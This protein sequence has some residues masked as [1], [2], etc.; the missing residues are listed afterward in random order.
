MNTLFNYC[1]PLKLETDYCN[2]LENYI[3]DNLQWV[4]DQIETE[5]NSPYWHQVFDRHAW[6]QTK[7]QANGK[8][9][10]VVV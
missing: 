5:P 3:Q 7:R 10:S 4:Q 2:H 8:A 1:G 9:A 6:H